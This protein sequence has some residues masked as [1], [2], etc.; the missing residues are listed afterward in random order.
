M[1]ILIHS[2]LLKD[3]DHKINEQIINFFITTK[4]ISKTYII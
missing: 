3:Y 2:E 1:K 4:E